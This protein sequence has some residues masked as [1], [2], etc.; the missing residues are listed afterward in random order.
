MTSTLVP[1]PTA[2]IKVCT[3]ICIETGCLARNDRRARRK[4]QIVP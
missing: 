4:A 1:S 2:R 3:S